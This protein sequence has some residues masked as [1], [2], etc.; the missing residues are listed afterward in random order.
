MIS[1]RSMLRAL[2][3]LPAG[4]AGMALGAGT[5]RADF[6]TMVDP[7]TDWGVWEGWGTSLG[8]WAKH[9]GPDPALADALF[10]RG[11]TQLLG[12]TVPGLGL[13][14]VRYNVGASGTNSI[15]G[16]TMAP[17]PVIDDYKHIEG[18]QLDW[19]SDDPGSSS[20]NWNADARQRDM[21][22]L[23]RDR[24]ADVFEL[25]SN[26]PMWWMLKNNDPFGAD[27][28][29]CNLND[30][31][32]GRHAVYLATVARY[33]HD[34][35][36]ID[37]SSV[38]PVNEPGA[39]WGHSSW[40]H[41]QE[42][43]HFSPA[44][45]AELIA[46]TRTQLDVRGLGWM[47]VA[48]LDEYNYDS[49]LSTW[50]ALDDDTRQRID[51]VN[52]HGY[53]PGQAREPLY[54]ATAAAGKRIWQ[55]EYTD[56]RAD[57]GLL[58]D[59]IHREL[60]QLHATAFVYWQILDTGGYGAIGF[61]GSEVSAVN[62]KFFVLAHY[63]RHIRPG[64]RIIDAGHPD[65]VAAY[66]DDAGKLVVVVVNSGDTQWIDVHLSRF[67]VIPAEGTMVDRW[68]TEFDGGRRYEHRLDTR[69]SGRRFWSQFP[70]RSVQTFEVSGIHR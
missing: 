22:W 31:D 70:A 12:Q 68:C 10:G 9:V 35:W 5:A 2:A 57:G 33:A 17:A 62:T 43:C 7:Q 41:Q 50:N 64:M 45:Q 55:S 42:G 61:D 69:I 30:R 34:H 67:G 25:F 8:W 6:A 63:T 36:G 27:D 11:Q 18:Y 29:D 44:Q 40:G 53:S 28:G 60:R 56:W 52:V 47:Q 26:S 3:A 54:A 49:A 65:V 20:W 15:E 66:D 46:H 59:N 23:A 51:K 21:M 48:G 1:R 39:R 19:Y 58:A 16:R 24:G 13:N 4:A 37:F 14:I 32:F 38:Q